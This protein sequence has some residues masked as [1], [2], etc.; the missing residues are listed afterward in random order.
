MFNL[1]V[2]LNGQTVTITVCDNSP[3]FNYAD[4]PRATRPDAGCCD[5]A[6]A[7]TAGLADLLPLIVGIIELLKKFGILK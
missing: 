3:P 2:P 1:T 4:S 5:K 6:P 7:G